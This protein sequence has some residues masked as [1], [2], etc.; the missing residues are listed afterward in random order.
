MRYEIKC[1][2]KRGETAAQAERMT[3][4][5]LKQAENKKAIYAIN[6]KSLSFLF[7][8]YS[9]KRATRPSGTEWRARAEG[10]TDSQKIVSRRQSRLRHRNSPF[11]SG[12]LFSM[13]GLPLDKQKRKGQLTL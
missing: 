6:K 1:A 7:F 12:Q 4:F 2:V 3:G 10:K 8:A 9:I 13:N 5:P 11:E